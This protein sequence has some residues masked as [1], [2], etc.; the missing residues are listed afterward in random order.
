MSHSARKCVA[1]LLAAFLCGSFAACG[2]G[3]DDQGKPL[4]VSLRIDGSVTTRV[5]GIQTAYAEGTALLANLVVSRGGVFNATVFRGSAAGY[6]L[7]SVSADPESSLARR[8]RDSQAVLAVLGT[9]LSQVLG[10]T[11][12]TQ[13]VAE[14]LAKLPEGSAVG[15]AL[16]EAVADVRSVPGERWAVVF[17]D[18]INNT[19]GEELPL[20]NV[21]RTAEILR[22][23]VGEVD[24]TDVNIALVGIGVSKE[25][26]GS[27][28]AN[29]LTEAWTQVCGELQAASCAI[30]QEATLPVALQEVGR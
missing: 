16:R 27:T 3:K 12:M 19:D 24:A 26:I 17:S 30:E 20:G 5:A 11:E 15:D 23:A 22:E 28:R 1:V 13:P 10:L 25:N 8:R 9:N 2:A 29:P 14:G 18:G 21:S 7:G 4:V 6:E